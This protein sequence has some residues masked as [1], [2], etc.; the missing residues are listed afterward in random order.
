MLFE[1]V[2]EGFDND[3][4]TSLHKHGFI[5]RNEKS[6]QYFCFYQTDKLK[7]DYGFIRESEISDLLNLNSWLDKEKRADF[8]KYCGQDLKNFNRLPFLHKAYSMIQF[9]GYEEIMGKSINSLTYMEVIDMI[10]NE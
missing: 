5:C 1:S 9:F 6:D 10:E 4:K 2:F 7:Y 3:F 8:L